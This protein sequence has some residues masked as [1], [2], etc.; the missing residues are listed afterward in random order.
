MTHLNR[1]AFHDTDTPFPSIVLLWENRPCAAIGYLPESTG[2]LLVSEPVVF[3]DAAGEVHRALCGQLLEQVNRRA[4]SGGFQRLHLLLPASA[5]D[6]SFERLLMERGFV[7]TTRIVQWDIS[8]AASDPC[9]PQNR[10]TIQ[11]Y[12]FAANSPAACEIQ[13]AIDAILE[14]S[15]DL[16]SQPPP[17]AAELLTK[18]QRLQAKVFVYRI[19]HEIAGLMSCV[20][21]PIKSAA[22]PSTTLASKANVCIEYIG[23]VPAF[24]RKQI[25]SVMIR[26]IPTLLSS[27]DDTHNQSSPKFETGHG[28]LT[29]HSG[30]S[31][32]PDEGRGPD[33]ISRIVTQAL[34]VTA[35]AD[36]A[37]TPAN[38]LYQSCGFVQTTRHH[39]WCCDLAK[40]HD[41]ACG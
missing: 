41:H 8:V 20:T 36:A 10:S 2:T 17:I 35:Y 27:F 15:E 5:G 30:E 13:S 23:V 11:L 31:Q 1:F 37:N 38:S 19:D 33:R 4:V 21:N 18:W 40:S 22:A 14:C 26:R 29:H 25:A 6:T 7:Q 34:T 9:S 16:T 12:D 3:L 24:R 39:L 32:L 28:P